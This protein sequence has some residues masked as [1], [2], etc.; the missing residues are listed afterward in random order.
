MKIRT[1]GSPEDEFLTKEEIKATPTASRAKEIRQQI[2]E[3]QAMKE[4]MIEENLQEEVD[5]IQNKNLGSKTDP[6]NIIKS[7]IRKGEYYEEVKLYGQKW[8]LRA[9]DQGDLLSAIDGIGD[10]LDSQSGRITALM[11][12]QVIYSIEALNGI[13][14]AEWFPEVKASSFSKTEE[15][16]IAVKRMLMLFLK[17]LGPKIIDDLYTEYA[18]ISE[19]RNKS[20]EELKNS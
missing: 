17:G 1:P 4:D 16:R 12:A 15:Y 3:Q 5:F 7:L 14:I 8:T 11:Y 6:K 19:V 13:P 18:R 10:Y 20:L 2:D 9:L